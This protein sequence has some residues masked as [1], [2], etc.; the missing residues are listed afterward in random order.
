MKV[1]QRF[2]LQNLV[3]L[4]REVHNYE[5]LQKNDYYKGYFLLLLGFLDLSEED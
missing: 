5:Y 1:D 3:S 4:P 2:A